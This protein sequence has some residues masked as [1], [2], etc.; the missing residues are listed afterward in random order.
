MSDDGEDHA[1]GGSS[2]QDP[3]ADQV[4]DRVDCD[5]FIIVSLPVTEL[6]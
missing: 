5:D 3:E 1:D 4:Q 2:E 6:R